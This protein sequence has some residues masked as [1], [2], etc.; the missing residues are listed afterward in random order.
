MIKRDVFPAFFDVAIGTLITKCGFMLIIFFMGF[1]SG[2]PFL[3]I[4]GTLKLWLARELVD[5]TTIGYFSW[6]GLAYSLKFLWA[7]LL[8]HYTLFR[9]GR[10]RSWILITQIFLF[11]KLKKSAAI[12][13]SFPD[14]LFELGQKEF[15]TFFQKFCPL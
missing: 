4:S 10:R 7:P 11:F 15:A 13:H 8:D 5:I 6:V 3:L 12:E 1:S 9:L 14:W 2:L